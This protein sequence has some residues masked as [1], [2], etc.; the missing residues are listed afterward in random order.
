MAKTKKKKHPLGALLGIPVVLIADLLVLALAESLDEAMA[1]SSGVNVV[2]AVPVYTIFASFIM[3][4]I[5]VAVLMYIAVATIIRL[6]R[7]DKEPDTL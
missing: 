4:V 5:T 7:R 3:T 2:E 6:M 1:V